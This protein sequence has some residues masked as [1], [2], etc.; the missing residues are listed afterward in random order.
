MRISGYNRKKQT[1]KSEFSVPL[2]CH[3]EERSDEGSCRING[4][5]SFAALS[6]T[7]EFKF[8]FTAFF[9]VTAKVILSK[10]AEGRAMM[11]TAAIYGA[12]MIANEHAQA[13]RAL[14][15][16]IAA[17]VCRSEAHAKAFAECFGIPARGTDPAL[18]DGAD[19]V[20][21]CTPPTAHF[22]I[23]SELLKKGK[24]IIC[25]K[26]LCLDPAQAEEL[27]RLAEEA[28][29]VCAVDFN[30]RHH[31]A[32]QRAKQLISAPEFGRVLLL[33]GS[34]LQ[35][36]GA[37]PALLDWRYDP[38]VS[39][40]MHAVTEIGSHWMDLA[41]YLSG[42]KITAVSAEFD[43]FHPMRYTKDGLIYHE[44]GRGR[45]PITVA[46]EDAAILNFRFEGGAIGCVML[47]EISHG[48]QNRLSM[49]ITGEYQSLWWSSEEGNRL[50]CGQKGNGVREE[51]FAFA[52]GFSETVKSLISSVYRD[53]LQKAPSG[54]S[55]C[56]TFRDGAENVKLCAA[57]L[58]S[59]QTNGAWVKL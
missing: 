15:I 51:L 47:S 31:L 29:T 21:I 28:G 59:A 55:G 41:Q 22:E 3:P 7:R 18:L 57:A 38:A 19:C 9:R 36:F 44:Q 48:R 42:R 12:G 16:P 43:R 58:Q 8:R 13:L 39:G 45:T 52:G 24:H 56:P 35:E 1:E 33:H 53:I 30:V 17:V 34:Y 27:A 14:G 6:M 5:R 50:C 54:T 32:L 2:V 25:E 40:E 10:G 26:P 37:E 11:P 20:H 46:S 49:E 23:I 4:S